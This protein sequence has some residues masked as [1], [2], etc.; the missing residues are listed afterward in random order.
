MIY[1]KSDNEVKA[2]IKA[3][4]IAGS[5]LKLAGQLAKP[6]ISTKEIDRQVHEYILKCGAH[7]ILN[8]GG[9]PCRFVLQLKY[10]IHGILQ[11]QN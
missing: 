2:M 6:G 4:N 11:I 5:A 7:F 10:S 3:G 8:Y 1:I 9:F